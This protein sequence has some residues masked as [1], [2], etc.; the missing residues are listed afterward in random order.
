MSAQLARQLAPDPPS[1]LRLRTRTGGL[2]AAGSKLRKRVAEADR[3]TRLFG[4][5]VRIDGHEKEVLAVEPDE[6]RSRASSDSRSFAES[7]SLKFTEQ[8]EEAEAGFVERDPVGGLGRQPYGRD[9]PYFVS[10]S[11]D[12][13][14]WDALITSAL[15][16]SPLEGSPA[17]ASASPDPRP[18]PKRV[19]DIGC[20][21]TPFWILEM[22]N[23]EA[24]EETEFVGLDVAPSS[25]T[26][27]LP[28]SMDSRISFIQTSFL[29]PLPF[30]AEFDYVRVAH[31]NLA[32]QEQDWTSLLD[33]ALRVLKAGGLLEVVEQD[34]STWLSRPDPSTPSS[35]R[36]AQHPIDD[37]FTHAFRADFINPR[38]LSVLPAN[39]AMAGISFS[40]TG[41]IALPMSTSSVAQRT[42]LLTSAAGDEVPLLSKY[43]PGR[44]SRPILREEDAYLFLHAYANR[45]AS[46]SY[47][48]AD[49]ALAGK[50]KEVLSSTLRRA[51]A[52]FD[53]AQSVHSSLHPARNSDSERL[54][55]QG[56]VH[57]WAADLR[58]RADLA[59]LITTRLNWRPTFEHALLSALEMNL[60]VYEKQFEVLERKKEMAMDVFGEVEA[61]QESRIAQVKSARRE[62]EA[63]LGLVR[64]RLGLD[65]HEAVE[66]T[67]GALEMEVFVAKADG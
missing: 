46:S 13:L 2:L 12:S 36:A 19:L 7:T 42:S 39:F 44:T 1:P 37:I 24:W 57:D 54:E 30:R 4:P 8:L 11:H 50:Q 48:L 25:V 26:I 43:V 20:G 35:S 14:D 56:R 45:W 58:D 63:E 3:R 67:L 31:V 41:R 61:E 47:G 62:V 60:P 21:I 15:I 34:H 27:D 5:S 29:L 53:D 51:P 17:F 23:K 10:Y 9:G 33:E 49:A 38:P 40:S 64:R 59:S 6:R 65:S 28:A 18:V 16:H 66:E 32:L 52:D 55:L 22:A